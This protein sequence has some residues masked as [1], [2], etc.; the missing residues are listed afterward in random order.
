MSVT[1]DV[2]ENLGAEMH[3]LFPV[4]A[5]RVEAEGARAGDASPDDEQLLTDEGRSR[6][7]ASVAARHALEAGA[8]VELAVSTSRLLFFDPDSGLAVSRRR[9]VVSAA[10]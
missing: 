6:F 2:V 3:V 9:P 4:D 10:G 8:Q 1:V 7:T 5:P